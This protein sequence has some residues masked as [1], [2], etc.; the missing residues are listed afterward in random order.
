MNSIHP[1]PPGPTCSAEQ[2]NEAQLAL[3]SLAELKEHLALC[4]KDVQDACADHVERI[5]I[6]ICD[7]IDAQHP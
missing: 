3:A 7:W 6:S 4:A 1:N 5:D 2:W